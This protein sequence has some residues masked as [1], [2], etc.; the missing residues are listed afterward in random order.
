LHTGLLP[1]HWASA[2]HGTHVA[3]GVKQTGVAPLH[4]VA[5]VAEHCAQAPL[6][7]QAGVVLGQSASAPQARQV[8]AVVLQTGVVPPHWA[9]DVQGTQVALAVSQAGVAPVHAVALVA[10]H[11][12]QAPLAWQ[13]GVAPPQSVSPAQAR[14]AW[15]VVLQTGVAPPHWAFDVQG[16]QMPFVVKH[17][18]V[19]PPHWLRFVAEHWPHEP[20]A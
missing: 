4:F 11:C 12:A 18:G 16:T 7:W 19:V 15:A 13:A 6:D 9:F 3:V 2:R 8:W 10:E 17:A 14:Q 5:F 20:P 1:P